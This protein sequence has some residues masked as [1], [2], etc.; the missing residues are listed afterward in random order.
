[1]TNE[2]FFFYWVAGSVLVGLAFGFWRALRAYLKYR[3]TRLVTCPENHSP[4]A[5]EVDAR[6]AAGKAAFEGLDLKLA[7]C[8]R[9]P[10]GQDCGRVCLRQIEASPENCLVRNILTKWYND[11][12]CVYCRR[13]MGE[14]R[15]HAHKPAL[16]S[17]EGKS[18]EWFEV[19]PETIP[20][21]L[22]THQP[23]CWNCH[24]SERFRLE[25]PDL[26][27]DRNYEHVA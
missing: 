16:L 27:V 25:H 17:P 6:Y 2:Q 5:V 19:R 1:M 26:V 7:S 3:G 23:V 22:A 20:G 14:I 21:V 4:A 8:S 12:E 10:E 24:I 9:W 13:P 15:W 18:V 11:K